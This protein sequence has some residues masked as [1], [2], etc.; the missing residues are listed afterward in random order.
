M[1]ESLVTY[2]TV[3]Y[4]TL[5][6]RRQARKKKRLVD[7]QETALNDTKV[8]KTKRRARDV[9]LSGIDDASLSGVRS[10]IKQVLPPPTEEEREEREESRE[11]AVRVRIPEMK[12][13]IDVLPEGAVDKAR[14]MRASTEAMKTKSMSAAQEY[15]DRH[16]SLRGWTVDAQLSD[17]SGLVLERNGEIKMA[18]RGTEKLTPLDWEQNARGFVGGE[19]NS[20]QMKEA[21]RQMQRVRA[22]Y[23]QYPSELLGYSRGGNMAM[24]LE[25]FL[26]RPPSLRMGSAEMTSSRPCLSMCSRGRQC[27]GTKGL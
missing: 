9:A 20:I 25:E 5:S 3:D 10:V 14:M 11:N 8:S 1:D 13:K 16:P 27:D 4:N 22:K 19:E 18:Y 2:P 23:G 12:A 7:E 6:E 21:K 26:A 15:L 24:T 17:T